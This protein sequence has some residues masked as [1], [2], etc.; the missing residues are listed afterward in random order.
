ME[1]LTEA[2]EREHQHLGS[3]TVATGTR[4]A[5]Q[6][7]FLTEGEVEVDIPPVP[8]VESRQEKYT[9]MMRARR[10]EAAARGRGR[11][12]AKQPTPGKSN[13]TPGA[14]VEGGEQPS[15]RRRRR[16]RKR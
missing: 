8:G 1:H 15:G 14:L 2:N 7:R 6:A 11:T 10:A 16:R 12:P 4:L 5:C 3:A 13:A 9:R